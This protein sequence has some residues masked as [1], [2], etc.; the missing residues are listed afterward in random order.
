[1]GTYAETANAVYRL[2]SADQEKQISVSV[3]SKQKE[4]AIFR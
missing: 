1:M 3:F 4:V 2:S